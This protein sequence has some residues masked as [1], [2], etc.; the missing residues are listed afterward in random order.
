MAEIQNWDLDGTLCEGESWTPE[1]CLNAKP[2]I[3]NIERLNRQFIN[4]YIVIQTARR[5]EN[6]PAT[7]EW[8]RRNNVRFH[9][10]SNFKSYANK[11]VDV[12]AVRPD[13]L[14]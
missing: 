4:N 9:A 8:L 13:E 14:S 5:D 11:F 3:E 2:I 7:L 6:I 12:D 1:D 10:F